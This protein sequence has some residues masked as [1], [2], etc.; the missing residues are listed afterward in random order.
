MSGVIWNNSNQ[1]SLFCCH[2]DSLF[3]FFEFKMNLS[4]CSFTFK[5]TIYVKYLLILLFFND[6]GRGGGVVLKKLKRW[7]TS[8][9][10]VIIS[11]YF[12]FITRFSVPLTVCNFNKYFISLK[13][14]N[15]THKCNTDMK[16]QYLVLKHDLASAT[17]V[18]VVIVAPVYCERNKLYKCGFLQT[19][20][21][22][23]WLI[24]IKTII[25]FGIICHPLLYA[26]VKNRAVSDSKRMADEGR[27]MRMTCAYTSE[28][29]Y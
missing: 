5:S 12:V 18:F 10:V 24:S 25:R 23:W 8:R 6:N 16:R 29:F 20:S 4:R 28:H 17:H 19:Y 7:S 9:L 3:C 14:W 15:I 11:L 2:I 21:V 26:H 13:Q 22:I 27:G 1:N